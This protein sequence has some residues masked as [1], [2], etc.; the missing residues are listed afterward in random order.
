MAYLISPDYLPTIQDV[1][2]QQ[3][4]S[5][6][7][8]VLTA[9]QSAGQA[10]AISYLRQKYLVDAEF[11]ETAGWDFSAPYTAYERVYLNAGAYNATLTYSVGNYVLQNG[12][13]YR[14]NTAIVAPEAFTIANWDL[15]GARYT[16]Y[17]AQYPN[18]LFDFDGGVYKKDDVIYWKGKNYTC[19]Q[20]TIFASHEAQIQARLIQNIPQGNVFPD[21][22]VSGLAAWGA[23][24]GYE[25][26]DNT[27][28]DD[29]TY[30]TLG[31]NRDLQMVQKLIDIT[32][33]H[34]HKRIAPRNIPQL[35]IDAYMG[36]EAD[37]SIIGGELRYPVYSALGWLQSCARGEVTPNLPLIQPKQG[38]RVRFGGNTKN[39]NSW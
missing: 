22:P 13:V 39:I 29:T 28:I 37:R 10:E 19:I 24:V 3:I 7:L 6:N 30:W 36:A 1:N 38:N 14:C 4:I 11:T 2:L 21:D 25:V 35:R 34:L 9:A 8:N 17:Y 12:N 15:I 32:L 5:S 20:P 27:D 33:F 26:P 18:P 16:L 23:G 31:D